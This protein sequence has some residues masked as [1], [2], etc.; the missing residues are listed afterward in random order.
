[1]LCSF[2]TKLRAPENIASTRLCY[3]AWP[4]SWARGGLL[5]HVVL[6]VFSMDVKALRRGCMTWKHQFSN[7]TFQNTL[8][9]QNRY[10]SGFQ[11]AFKIPSQY[12]RGFQ[13]KN[14]Q[15]AICDSHRESYDVSTHLCCVYGPLPFASQKLATLLP[16]RTSLA[17]AIFL[18]KKRKLM[19]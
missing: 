15:S 18:S 7:N 8:F 19:L 17:I 9:Q 12:Y 6:V 13:E 2:S 16:E 1:M 11:V 5:I 14:P 10:H 3:L 4:S